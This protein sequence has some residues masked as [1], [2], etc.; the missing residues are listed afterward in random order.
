ML[1]AAERPDPLTATATALASVCD[2]A[3]HG[4]WKYV[5]HGL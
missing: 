4:L 2:N 3:L 1:W 5:S